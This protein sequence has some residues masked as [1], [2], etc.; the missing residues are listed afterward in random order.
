MIIRRRRRAVWKS[1]GKK[2]NIGRYRLGITIHS[3]I[4]CNPRKWPCGRKNRELNTIILYF[5]RYGCRHRHLTTIVTLLSSRRFAIL[6]FTGAPGRLLERV[7]I[8]SAKYGSAQLIPYDTFYAFIKIFYT[9]LDD[10][11]LFI[12]ELFRYVYY[13]AS[14]PAA[15]CKILSYTR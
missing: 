3:Y 11:G 9:L 12:G 15:N 2:K 14:W 4:I 13:A 8:S 6:L 7:W 10:D 5:Q 1:D